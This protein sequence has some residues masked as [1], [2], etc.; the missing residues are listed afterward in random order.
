[1]LREGFGRP[2]VVVTIKLPGAEKHC[3]NQITAQDHPFPTFALQPTCSDMQGYEDSNTRVHSAE[4]YIAAQTTMMQNW[5]PA[6]AS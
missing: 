3:P 5:G 2:G 6:A 4:Q 1:V